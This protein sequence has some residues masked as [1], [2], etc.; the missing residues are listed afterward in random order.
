MRSSQPPVV[1][2]W[3]LTRFCN[4]NEVLAGD[5]VEEY[6]RGRTVVWYWRQVVMA[7][8]VGCGSEIRMHKLLTVRAVITGWAA[9][10]PPFIQSVFEGVGRSGTWPTVVL[11]VALL[12]L[13]HS[14]FAVCGWFSQRLACRSLPSNISGRNGDN[15]RVISGARTLSRVL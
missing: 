2:T 5:L 8:L 10:I 13:P 1:A 6:A 9:L 3:V 4:R 14:L 12:H 7:I 15:V 11:V